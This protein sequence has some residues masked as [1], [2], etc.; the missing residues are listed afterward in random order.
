VVQGLS[1][2]DR[3][4][5]VEVSLVVSHTRGDQKGISCPYPPVT[6]EGRCEMREATPNLRDAFPALKFTDTLD[7]RSRPRYNRRVVSRTSKRTAHSTPN[8]TSSQN[9]GR[10]YVEQT[11][12]CFTVP[13]RGAETADRADR[14]AYAGRRYK[15][16]YSHLISLPDI[17]APGDRAAAH[18]VVQDVERAI[19]VGGW[20]TNE[21]NRLRRMQQ[22]W[23]MRYLGLDPGFNLRGWRRQGTGHHTPEIEKVFSSIRKELL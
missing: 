6:G 13:G 3:H 9:V 11:E 1:Q 21:W 19:E 10:P 17:V 14:T 2:L 23:T 4:D 8:V 15:S 5:S 16:A 22:A 18:R 12:S 7:S 20:T